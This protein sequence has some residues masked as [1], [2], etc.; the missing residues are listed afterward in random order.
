MAPSHDSDQ[1][2]CLTRAAAITDSSG[3]DARLVVGAG[4]QGADV[5]VVDAA[6]DLAAGDDRH[7]LARDQADPPAVE[8]Q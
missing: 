1:M 5:G 4:D 6:V 2:F 8:R 3:D 7:F